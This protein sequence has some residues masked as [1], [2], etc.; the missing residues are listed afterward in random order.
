M[1]KPPPIRLSFHGQ[2]HG[3]SRL[4]LSAPYNATWMHVLRITLMQRRVTQPGGRVAYAGHPVRR[5]ARS[6]THARTPARLMQPR[7]FSRLHARH[8]RPRTFIFEHLLPRI[9]IVDLPP[10]STLL[11]TRHREIPGDHSRSESFSHRDSRLSFYTGVLLNITD[12]WFIASLN[13][14][15]P[16]TFFIPFERMSWLHSIHRR[17]LH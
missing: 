10:V 17:G 5:L 14:N 13:Y 7:R 3:V 9:S 12:S 16:F 11:S 4:A 1:H 8:A 2:F 15:I 6:H